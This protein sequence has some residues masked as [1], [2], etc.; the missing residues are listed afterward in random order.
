MNSTEAEYAWQLEAMKAEGEI[1]EYTF[2]A[3]PFQMAPKF[4]YTPDFEVIYADGHREFH[5]IKGGR[6][7]DKA[8]PYFK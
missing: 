1:L 2:E 5:E 6:I 3:F 4:S 7:H 8:I